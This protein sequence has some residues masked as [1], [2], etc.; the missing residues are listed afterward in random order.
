MNSEQELT[1][2]EFIM[3]ESNDFHAPYGP[4][5]EF[6]MAVKNGET[7]KVSKLCKTEFTDKSGFGKLSENPLQSIKYHFVVTAALLARYC[8]EGGM[9]HETAYSLSDLYIQKADRCASF[10]EISRLHRQM[11]EDY[12]QRMSQL[13]KERIFSKPIVKCV[14]YIY[15]N[16]HK[17]ILISDLAK[18][19]GLNES[20][21]SRLFKKE[22]GLTVTQYVQNEKLNAARNMLTFSDYHPSQIASLLAF[23]N[24]SYFIK[25]FSEKNGVTPKK[26][27]DLHF[28]RVGIDA[29]TQNKNK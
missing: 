2:K 20:Y 25:V 14:D 6:Y 27:R 17:R 7:E 15:N 23:S 28:R 19:T 4:E 11:S 16:L 13:R 24:Q 22:T 21:L 12:T 29:S 5:F 1:Y 3:R 8:I 26:Y 9:A 10:A 18:F